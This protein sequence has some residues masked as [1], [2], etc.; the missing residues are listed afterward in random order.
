MR[1]KIKDQWYDD[2]N[3]GAVMVELTDKDKEN[4]AN[5]LPEC[6]KYCSYNGKK[7]TEEEI[8]V[9]MELTPECVELVAENRQ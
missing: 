2:D 8:N 4:I 1:V 6:S 9:F 7:F 5:M 3:A